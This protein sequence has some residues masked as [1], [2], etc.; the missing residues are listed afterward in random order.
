[1]EELRK[2]EHCGR[3]VLEEMQLL[4]LEWCM[5]EVIVMYVECEKC[6]EKG[7]HVEENRGQGVIRNRQKWCGCSKGRERKA[8][9]PREGKAQQRNTRPR[10]LESTAKERGS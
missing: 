3:G 10:G 2:E 6:G 9:Y 5:R 4:E 1:V 8:V 7:C